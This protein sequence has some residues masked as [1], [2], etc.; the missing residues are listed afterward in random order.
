MALLDQFSIYDKEVNTKL[1]GGHSD[2]SNN[3][4]ESLSVLKDKIDIMYKYRNNQIKDID[5]TETK[6]NSPGIIENIC[7]AHSFK[8][9]DDYQKANGIYY[10]LSLGDLNDALDNMSYCTCNSRSVEGCDCVVRTS[11][12]T[13]QCNLRSPYECM[14]VI[15]TG[16]KYVQVCNCNIRD[17]SCSCV[18]RTTSAGCSCNSRCSCNVVNEYDKMPPPTSCTCVTRYYDSGCQ[19]D[20]RTVSYDKAVNVPSGPCYIVDASSG[21][22]CVARQ[23]SCP[24]NVGCSYVGWNCGDHIQPNRVGCC[25]CDI[26]TPS[27]NEYI[28]GA[29]Q[30]VSRTQTI[31]CSYNV[32]KMDING[33]N[34][35]P[36]NQKA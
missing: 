35:L 6:D 20:A 29:C 9:F 27:S 23:S 10:S 13:C 17:N 4:Y 28:T 31:G 25:S 18:N 2:D 11:G 21:C 22:S 24:G 12:K 19:C 14:C 26:R 30:C 5:N 8:S 1:V 36:K 3:R 32:V 15:R 33:K 34:D 7:N 16:N